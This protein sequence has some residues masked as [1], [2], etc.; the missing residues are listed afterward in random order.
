[1]LTDRQKDTLT[2]LSFGIV[3]IILIVN[4]GNALFYR[5]NWSNHTQGNQKITNNQPN[6]TCQAIDPV[7][8]PEYNMREIAKQSI[9]LEEHL[10]VRD[11]YCADCIKKHFLHCIGLAEEAA[12]LVCGKKQ[13]NHLPYLNE[14]GPFYKAKFNE[15]LNKCPMWTQE[16]ANTRVK[17]AGEIRD[18]RKAIVNVYAS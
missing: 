3:S 17:I 5:T 18:F 1:M 7:S 14:A 2:I 13:G 16:S 12:M 4:I 11:K 8:E 9:L 15:W 10:L 6:H